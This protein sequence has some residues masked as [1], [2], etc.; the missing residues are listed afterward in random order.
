MPQE[1]ERKQAQPA[2]GAVGW[3]HALLR[4]GPRVD[5]AALT[6]LRPEA[7][8]QRRHPQLDLIRLRFGH[9]ARQ[10]HAPD[11][12]AGPLAAGGLYEEGRRAACSD[13]RPGCRRAQL[14]AWHL[15]PCQLAACGSRRV[16]GRTLN[17]D[18]QLSLPRAQARPMAA[19][20]KAA[21]PG[22]ARPCCSCTIHMPKTTQVQ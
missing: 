9:G 13:I 10:P 16:R 20:T 22:Q 1:P 7:G 19:T 17:P 21:Y 2:P 5:W 11:S 12:Y 3:L 4:L 15:A 18:V 8:A 14:G 6:S